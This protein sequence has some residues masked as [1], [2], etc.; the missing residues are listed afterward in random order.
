MKDKH[1]KLSRNAEDSNRGDKMKDKEA[2]SE[3]LA[4]S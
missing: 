3:E 2:T 4:G 1:E